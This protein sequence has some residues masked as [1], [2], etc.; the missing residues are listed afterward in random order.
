MDG[1]LVSKPVAALD[2]IVG[3]IAPIVSMHVSK[4]RV[5]A[6]LGSHGVRP[7]WEKFG[8]T[9]SF[10]ALFYQAESCSEA[11]PTCSQ[12][13]CIEGV[14]DDSIF[15]EESVLCVEWSYLCVFAEGSVAYDSEATAVAAE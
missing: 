12:D 11:G 2:S 10:E 14:V 5:D 1:V 6:S 3:V 4:S 13:Y 15:L 7:G 9:G 8:N